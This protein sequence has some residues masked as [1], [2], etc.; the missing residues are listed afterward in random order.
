MH[1]KTRLA[2]LTLGKKTREA[3]STASTS[4]VVPCFLRLPPRSLAPNSSRCGNT[5]AGRAGLVRRNEAR[6]YDPPVY[7]FRQHPDQC[8][9]A[10]RVPLRELRDVQDGSVHEHP[11]L[12]VQHLECEQAGRQA[13][14]S[15]Q[16][17]IGTGRAGRATHTRGGGASN[18]E[19]G[20]V[21][22]WRGAP[23]P[24]SVNAF[25]GFQLQDAILH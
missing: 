3:A 16:D 12:A 2:P 9:P 13:V 20:V 7:F 24:F 1:T 11:T 5:D 18:G 4:Y 25:L 22:R 8:T 21:V 14:T 19:T 15:C 10:P 6:A 23:K 17:N